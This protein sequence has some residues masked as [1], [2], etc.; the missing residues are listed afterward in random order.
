MWEK[1]W[2]KCLVRQFASPFPFLCGEILVRTSPLESL[3]KISNLFDIFLPRKAN[4]SSFVAKGPLWKSD[5]SRFTDHPIKLYAWP[6]N[7]NSVQDWDMLL[8]AD[9]VAIHS[10]THVFVGQLSFYDGFVEVT[11]RHLFHLH[12]HLFN[13]KLRSHPMQFYS[14]IDESRSARFSQ[15]PKNIKHVWYFWYFIIWNVFD[16]FLARRTSHEN[17]AAHER[18]RLRKLPPPSPRHF[19]QLFPHVYGGL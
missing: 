3:R 17:F 13:S 9:L 11:E 19:A 6:T 8:V 14:M 2:T 5:W 1:S 7:V 18:K 4:S 15:L 12:R 10:L 16:I